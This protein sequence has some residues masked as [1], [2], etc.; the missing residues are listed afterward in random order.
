V[1]RIPQLLLRL[2]SS[3]LNDAEKHLADADPVMAKLIKA[4]GPCTLGRTSEDPFVSLAGSIIGQQLSVKA[5]A[6][7]HGRLLEKLGGELTPA[8]VAIIKA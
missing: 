7:I 5:A 8:T 4:H 1:W 3:I 2:N 6:T